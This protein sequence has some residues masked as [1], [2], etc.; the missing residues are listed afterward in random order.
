MTC[1]TRISG[2]EAPA[3]S[4]I[5]HVRR[6]AQP[7]GQL[8]QPVAVAAGRAADDDD[9]V[10]GGRQHLDGILAVLRGVAD[11]LLLRFTH[12][13]KPVLHRGQDL[14]RVVHAERGLRHH[15][16]LVAARANARHIGH[17][18][19]QVDP[20]AQLPH[21]ALDLGV[22]LVAD[23]DE[24]VSFL[25][26]LGHLDMHLGD[27]RTGGV[28]DPEATLGGF[29]TH[30]LAHAVRAE[31][32]RR[33]RRHVGQVLDKDRPLGPEVIDHIGVVH[34]LVPHVDRPSE[35]AQRT[36]DDLDRTVDAGA[37]AARLGQHH[38]VDAHVGHHSTPIS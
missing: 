10:N 28:V 20:V 7:L 24:F 11:V 17:F 32:Q 13:R 16:Q 22:P 4:R 5:D 19:D 12:L 3:L 14:R 15:R 31:H 2:A 18:L 30:R 36:L 38:L 9:H 6:R 37:E 8:A 33:A 26:Q 27:Q 1:C 23:H 21:R 34:D 29:G 35:L 25:G